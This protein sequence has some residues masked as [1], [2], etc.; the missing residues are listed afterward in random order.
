MKTRTRIMIVLIIALAL[1]AY[2]F[3]EN[4]YIVGILLLVD[5]A[6]LGTVLNVFVTASYI[7][8]RRRI[9]IS[10]NYDDS[11]KSIATF[12]RWMVDEKQICHK[13]TLYVK[14]ELDENDYNLIA[15][16]G[17]TDASPMYG[18]LV[19]DDFKKK[20]G[21]IDTK[22]YEPNVSRSSNDEKKKGFIFRENVVSHAIFKYE[23]KLSKNT[24]DKIIHAAVYF[25]WVEKPQEFLLAQ[26]KEL[27]EYKDE[28]LP[29][30]R[31]LNDSSPK[32]Q[33]AKHRELETRRWIDDHILS[34]DYIKFERLLLKAMYTF[35][36]GIEA[37]KLR[38]VVAWNNDDSFCI[39]LDD[40]QSDLEIRNYLEDK[41]EKGI[42]QKKEKEN[43]LTVIE[44]GPLYL[45]SE[46]YG[47]QII[48]PIKGPRRLSG[49]T[50]SNKK[51]NILGVLSIESY[52]DKLESEMVKPLCS[53]ADH[54]GMIKE[55]LNTRYGASYTRP[56]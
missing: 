2:L 18:P 12:L 1:A 30:A 39:F 41:F 47:R 34:N 4:N 29:A 52:Q 10:E 22:H 55:A 56:E 49:I 15:H 51:E 21:A 40:F 33:K 46:K 42:L 24:N 7:P 44:H 32:G 25:N 27:E 13:I 38:I 37:R 26:Q 16:Y 54:F 8:S 53:L 35:L 48:V 5:G 45:L 50:D 17:L 6:I 28:L 14:D 23:E 43:Y 11:V 36:S 3:R 9:I 20:L 19:F 31:K